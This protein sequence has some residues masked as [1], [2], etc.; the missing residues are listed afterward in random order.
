MIFKQHNKI[1][2]IA[3][4]RKFGVIL[5]CVNTQ[6]RDRLMVG[7]RPLK[8]SI[9]VRIQVPQLIIFSIRK[10][11]WQAFFGNRK[12][13]IFRYRLRCFAGNVWVSSEG[14]RSALNASMRGLPNLT[15]NPGVTGAPTGVPS[16]ESFV[17]LNSHET[18]DLADGSGLFYTQSKSP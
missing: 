16:A 3:K 1:C 11:S 8:A 14:C 18:K 4:I 15:C 10:P 9:L 2:R 5:M 13:T 17:E 6:L 12:L 7:H